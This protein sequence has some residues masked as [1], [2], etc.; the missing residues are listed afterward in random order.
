MIAR[1]RGVAEAKDADTVVVDVG[2]VGL[3]LRVTAA[4]MRK[5]RAASGP[6][7]LFTHLHVRENELALFGFAAEE[8]LNLFELLLTVSGV[9]P[10]AGLSILS[11]VEPATLHAAIAQGNVEVLT[12][13]RGIGRKTAQRIMLELRGKIELSEASAEMAPVSFADA[14]ALTALTALGYSAAEAQAALRAAGE[15]GLSVEARVM[16]AL[17]HIGAGGR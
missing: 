2:G 16:A 8:E 12:G 6:V 4:A 15:P 9:G 14:E 10:T 11:N 1:V 7:E 3:K 17:R 5:A 13:V